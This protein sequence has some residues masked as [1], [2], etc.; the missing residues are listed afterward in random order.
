MAFSDRVAL[1]KFY[2]ADRQQ[3]TL[4]RL[5][6]VGILAVLM[7]FIFQDGLI[8]MTGAWESAEYSHG[9]LIP[10]IT[11]FLIWRNRHQLAAAG[12]KGS[13]FGA[14]VVF[15]GLAMFIMGELGTLYTVIQYAF[16][17]TLFGIVLAFVG[18]RG[19]RFLW[20]PLLYLVFMIPL[21]SFLYAGLSSTLQLIASE[22]GVTVI[23]FFGIS[24]FLDGNVIDLGVYKL[25]VV[26]ACSGLRYLF[27]LMSFGFLVVYL[28]RG[29]FWQ[30]GVVFLSTI[31]ITILMNS[32]R[33]GVI[34]VLVENY[35]IEMAEGFLHTFQGWVIFMALVLFLFGEIWLLNKIFGTGGSVFD[36]FAFAAPRPTAPLAAPLPQGQPA[37]SKQA[38]P[39]HKALPRPYMVSLAIVLLAA[40][41]SSLMG[42]RAEAALERKVFATLPMRIDDWRGREFALEPEIVAA[43]KV[44]DYIMA[45]Y[46]RESD[47]IPVNFYSAYY[48]SQ[49]KGEAVHSPQAC[50]PGG[51]WVIEEFAERRLDTVIA[52]GQPLTVNRAIIGKGDFQQLVYYW[53]P[54]RDRFL[55]NEY[56]VKWYIFWDALTRNRTD[57]ALVRLV[58]PVDGPDGFDAADQRLSDFAA[59]LMPKLSLYFP[60]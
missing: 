12:Q 19:M 18:W 14:L 44:T 60:S 56:W 27:P 30:K 37:Q 7:G 55:T 41:A 45:D 3:G 50:I 40:G 10:V 57:G 59:T 52:G 22:L 31:P 54:Q 33:I 43:L 32:F 1:G 38:A 5:T 9:Y 28:S 4:L 20:I 8:T 23:R 34:G 39:I 36:R 17:V 6:S 16:L 58:T 47:P 53:F 11:L 13:W 15:L 51:G 49:R 29:P 2:S 46:R 42:T 21:P 35:G 26:E 25:N 24:V 48:K